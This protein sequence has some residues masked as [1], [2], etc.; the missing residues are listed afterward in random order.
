MRYKAITIFKY[1]AF[2]FA[3]YTTLAT[4]VSKNGIAPGLYS[5]ESD[6]PDATR[7]SG[8]V[9]ISSDLAA[10]DD[11]TFIEFGL[12]RNPSGQLGNN[13]SYF[14]IE[15]ENRSCNYLTQ[16]DMVGMFVCRNK[17][18]NDI[19]CTVLFTKI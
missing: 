9:T 19:E 1:V 6:C 10:Q 4:S 13:S 15:D 7:K 14:T 2:A 12:P 3:I 17:L 11:E 18:T 16:D 5:V 8:Q